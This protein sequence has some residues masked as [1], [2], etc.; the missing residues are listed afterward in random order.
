MTRE[1]ANCTM[2]VNHPLTSPPHSAHGR[3]DGPQDGGAPSTGLGGRG[4]EERVLLWV[5]LESPD[6]LLFTPAQRV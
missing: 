5:G 3:C 6:V 4:W 2:M 1:S